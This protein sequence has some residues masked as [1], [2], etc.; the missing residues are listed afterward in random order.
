MKV[1][2][3]SSQKSS[4]IRI[5]TFSGVWGRFRAPLKH[6]RKRVSVYVL[7]VSSSSS[8]FVF[9]H[10]LYVLSQLVNK[11]LF[12]TLVGSALNKLKEMLDNPSQI[13]TF[14]AESLPSQSLFFICYI[15]LAT[16]TGYALQLLRI[17]PLIIVAIKRKWLVKTEREEKAAWRPPPVLYDRV[18]SNSDLGNNFLKLLGN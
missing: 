3:S 6:W 10:W 8:F 16:L 5:V 7:F 17:A 13:P 12:M 2:V 9:I 18:I 15:M 11:F 14:L 4:R 1:Y